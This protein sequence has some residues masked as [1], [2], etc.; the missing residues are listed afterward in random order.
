MEWDWEVGRYLSEQT[1][2]GLSSDFLERFLAEL[3][4][5]VQL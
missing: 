1:R 2:A 3:D 5:A 4:D